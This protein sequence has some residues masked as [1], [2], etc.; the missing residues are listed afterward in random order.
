MVHSRGLL[1]ILG[2]DRLGATEFPSGNY[3]SQRALGA[4]EVHF[5]RVPA[6]LPEGRNLQGRVRQGEG[7]VGQ[8]VAGVA[9]RV[10]VWPGVCP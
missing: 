2:Q 9:C 10:R 4:S 1:S 3:I 6:E 8:G 7:V 5:R